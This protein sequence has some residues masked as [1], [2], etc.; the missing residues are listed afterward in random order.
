[1]VNL[2]VEPPAPADASPMLISLVQLI[3]ADKI[4]I[5]IKVIKS[6]HYLQHLGLLIV[7]FFQAMTVLF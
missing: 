6:F 3:K 4:K 5:A 7:C 2:A 1:M